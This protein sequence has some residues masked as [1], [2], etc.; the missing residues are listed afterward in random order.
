MVS[1]EGNLSLSLITHTAY[2]ECGSKSVQKSKAVLGGN[3]KP[4]EKKE[5]VS[6]KIPKRQKECEQE[7][8]DK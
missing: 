7:K 2:L 1:K 6:Q 8:T 5:T 4:M 3:K